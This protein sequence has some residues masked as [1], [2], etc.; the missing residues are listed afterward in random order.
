MSLAAA[1][2][3]INLWHFLN[4]KAQSKQRV[5]RSWG[6]A[7][8]QIQPSAN[9]ASSW[10]EG[11]RGDLCHGEGLGPGGLES[12]WETSV[13]VC[14]VQKAKCCKQ[15]KPAHF[16]QITPVPHPLGG[17]ISKPLPPLSC[18]IP[19]DPHGSWQHPAPRFSAGPTLPQDQRTNLYLQNCLHLP[20]E[21]IRKKS[22]SC[23]TK[24]RDFCPKEGVVSPT[25][26]QQVNHSWMP[27]N[28]TLAPAL[29]PHFYFSGDKKRAPSSH[30]CKNSAQAQGWLH[31]PVLTATRLPREMNDALNSS[32]E[33]SCVGETKAGQE[34][35]LQRHISTELG[36]GQP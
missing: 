1:A 8:G 4:K 11:E 31:K 35:P 12:T 19:G 9:T 5:I 27:S 15:G 20:W 36:A 3:P 22:I 6:I 7:G 34:A 14:M 32:H 33:H 10:R 26:L 17:E 25:A 28:V 16:L 13:R 23:F 24:E 30:S 2:S 18:R 29:T 21:Q